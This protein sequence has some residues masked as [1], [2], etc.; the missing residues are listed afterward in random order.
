M[1]QLRAFHSYSESKDLYIDATSGLFQRIPDEKSA[2]L[3]SLVMRHP[4][5][6]RVAIPVAEM[7]STS[8][9]GRE[10]R[11]WLSVIKDT[12]RF[13][14]IRFQPAKIESDLSFAILQSSCAIFNM[15][16]LKSYMQWCWELHSKHLSRAEIKAK[17]VLHVCVAHM[18]KIFSRQ[19]AKSVKSKNLRQFILYCMGFMIN[20]GDMNRIKGLFQL[21]CMVLGSA[22]INGAVQT[23]VDELQAIVK[24][25]LQV[26]DSTEEELSHQKQTYDD[27]AEP[28]L[29]STRFYNAF[30]AIHDLRYVCMNTP[31]PNPYYAPQ[32]LD[33]LLR[34]QMGLI[35]L[36]T[37][38]MIG[39][40]GQYA[41]D[42]ETVQ[43]KT[44]ESRIG[45]RAST[46]CV[47]NY[48]RNI[49]G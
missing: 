18:M 34:N 11:H 16:D 3:Y 43:S 36:W 37:G 30:A 13:H 12:A 44:G 17:T 25:D 9:Y 14:G 40:I 27:T 10:I 32:F 24:G 6:N 38:L 47:E 4:L 5:G 39:D 45:L 49:K 19:A 7:V 20:L 2:Y 26:M 29:R 28:G 23:C 21:L 42:V 22:A 8:Q 46:S 33:D 1:E 15:C 31:T 48:F 35:P 41:T